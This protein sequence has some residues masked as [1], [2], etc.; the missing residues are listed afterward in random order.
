MTPSKEPRNHGKGKHIKRKYHLICEI[1]VK[2]DVVV[3]KITSME[4]LVDHF[5]KTLS[6]RIFDGHRDNLGIKCVPSM[7]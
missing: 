4:N 2:E 7:L 3:E 1:I 6:I 5:M